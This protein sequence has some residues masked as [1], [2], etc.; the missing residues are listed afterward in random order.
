[1]SRWK[2]LFLLAVICLFFADS[3]VLIAEKRTVGEV[4]RKFL[5]EVVRESQDA[6][7]RGITG[8][9]SQIPLDHPVVLRGELV[10]NSAIVK[11]GELVVHGGIVKHTRSRITAS[12][13]NSHAAAES[14]RPL[15]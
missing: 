12:Q 11:R 15:N 5:D 2:V 10:V 14:G 8:A 9:A 13:Q 7:P 4:D 6:A 1:M 3:M